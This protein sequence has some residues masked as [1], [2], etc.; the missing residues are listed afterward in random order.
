MNGPCWKLGRDNEERFIITAKYFQKQS[1][2]GVITG[3]EQMLGCC[4]GPFS[5]MCF[6]LLKRQVVTLFLPPPSHLTCDRDRFRKKITTIQSR[7]MIQLFQ[8]ENNQL[9]WY[10]SEYRSLLSKSK[11][12]QVVWVYKT[13]IIIRAIFT[14]GVTHVVKI[15]QA[16]CVK[17]FSAVG[18]GLNVSLFVWLQ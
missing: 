16:T 9:S 6:A 17:M 12:E 4:C 14:Y 15:S 10:S 18:N 7:Q 8:I 5:S 3:K 13:V 2:K 1:R 11:H